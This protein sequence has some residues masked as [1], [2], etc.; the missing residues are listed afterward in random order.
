M[1]PSFLLGRRPMH[2]IPL[3]ITRHLQEIALSG[4][5]EHAEK[6]RWTITLL[7]FRITPY[8]TRRD[9]LLTVLVSPHRKQIRGCQKLEVK[10]PSKFGTCRRAIFRDV[11]QNLLVGHRSN[12]Y[13][14]IYQPY[15]DYIQ[16]TVTKINTHTPMNVAAS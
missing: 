14:S 5:R 7:T 6:L 4:R 13:I 1:N 9:S 8:S 15:R 12:F 11:C 16:N 3:H 10:T 2:C